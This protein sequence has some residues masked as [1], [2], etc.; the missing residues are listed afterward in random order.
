MT[1]LTSL[2]NRC[3]VVIRE[4]GF[5]IAIAVVAALLIRSSL[6]MA[7]L[8]PSGSM[9][10]TMEIGDRFIANK[11]AYDLRIPFTQTSL[12]ETGEVERGDVVVFKPPFKAEHDYVKRVIGLP[13]DVIQIRNKV[14]FLNGE[15]LEEPHVRHVD[16][17]IQPGGKSPRDNLGPIRVPEG[18]LFVM[19][20]NRDESYDSRYWGYLPRKLVKGQARIIY[21]SFDSD[22]FGIRWSRLGRLF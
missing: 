18:A 4:Y 9:L 10:T 20:D 7:Y 14:L 21:W 12:I 16:P 11:A 8:V 17:G 1:K 13:G 22:R 19:G 6:V 3:P 5:S 15:R 2:W